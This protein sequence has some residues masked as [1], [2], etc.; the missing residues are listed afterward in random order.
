MQLSVPQGSVPTSPVTPKQMPRSSVKATLMHDAITGT[1]NGHLLATYDPA[2]WPRHPS[3][4]V[5]RKPQGSLLAPVHLTDP[6]GPSW[7]RGHRDVYRCHCPQPTFSSTRPA[8]PGSPFGLS[9][10]KPTPKHTLSSRT[11]S[12]QHLPPEGTCCPCP[13]PRLRRDL[14]ASSTAEPF[15]FHL[16]NTGQ[17]CLLLS[18]PRTISLA[19]P[20]PP[21]PP[22]RPWE[23]WVPPSPLP[24]HSD[25]FSGAAGGALETHRSDHALPLRSGSWTLMLRPL[26]PHAL[27]VPGM[28]W[29][30]PRLKALAHD[31]LFW[32]SA[33]R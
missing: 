31:E 33:Q 4:R 15:G 19:Q 28:F 26:V 1:A 18:F 5:V 9:Q 32:R 23:P 29:I 24:L 27:V 16:L 6:T 12:T 2:P 3:W 7:V 22:S 8:C 14:P 25:P 17:I 30:L 13:K 10:S 11:F 21:P 20:P